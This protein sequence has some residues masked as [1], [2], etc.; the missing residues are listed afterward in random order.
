[1]KK[2]RIV[3]E[4]FIIQLSRSMFMNEIKTNVTENSK[5]T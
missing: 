3:N 5:F 1:M 4:D 2:R